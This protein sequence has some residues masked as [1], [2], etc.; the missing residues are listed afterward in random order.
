MSVESDARKFWIAA[1]FYRR[2]LDRDRRTALA[3]LM[4]LAQSATGK[5]QSR[6]LTLLREIHERNSNQTS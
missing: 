1:F 5:A 3:V 2:A 4:Q 6:A